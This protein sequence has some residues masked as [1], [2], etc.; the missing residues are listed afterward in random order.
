MVGLNL[1][2]LSAC[3]RIKRH[4]HSKGIFLSSYKGRFN[5][6][7]SCP[8]QN[9]C[10][11]LNRQILSLFYMFRMLTEKTIK[12]FR[13]IT[14]SGTHTGLLGMTKLAL[15]TLLAL[16]QSEWIRAQDVDLIRLKQNNSLNF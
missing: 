12:H 5:H 6:N 16:D 14:V 8:E 10:M 3:R 9:V 11:E 1:Q 4:L 13:F 15:Y 7:K 2:G